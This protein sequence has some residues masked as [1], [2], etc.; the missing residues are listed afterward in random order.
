MDFYVNDIWSVT[1]GGAKGG[2]KGGNQGSVI[3][4]SHVHMRNA[5]E[6]LV[7]L[8]QHDGNIQVAEVRSGKLELAKRKKATDG[9]RLLKGHLGAV[10]KLLYLPSQDDKRPEMS[11]LLSCSADRTVRLW[12]P[13][14]SEGKPQCIQTMVHSVAGCGGTV[15][16]ICYINGTIVTCGT[17]S[18]VKIWQKQKGRELL[19]YPWYK[20]QDTLTCFGPDNWVTA[21][22]THSVDVPQLYAGDSKG[23]LWV[24]RPSH[25][26]GHAC[27]VD[28]T[29]PSA[30]LPIMEK[31]KKFERICALG[32]T[33]ILMLPSENFVIMLSNDYTATI[34]NILTHTPFAVL[35][36]PNRCAY[37]GC[38]WL[39]SRQE[40]YL[41]DE[42][43]TLQ[44]WDVYKSSLENQ[45]LLSRK[46][47]S[48]LSLV[49]EN[50]DGES[51]KV[52]R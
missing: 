6:S 48:G 1:P 28:N 20:L 35:D 24:F 27:E 10:K 19:L 40:L 49:R 44:R 43:G 5:E 31:W 17:D 25:T 41:S 26:A 8:G 4:C 30:P 47:V 29:Q 46:G 34:L 38:D 51:R 22:A 13:W 2:V 16:D 33:H 52:R 50:G 3:T 21:I 7:F 32:I 18:T 42:F 37:T 11:M 36:N 15:M 14:V 23:S 45:H 12:S 39:R 9:S